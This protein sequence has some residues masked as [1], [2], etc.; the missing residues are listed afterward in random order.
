MNSKRKIVLGVAIAACLGLIPVPFIYAQSLNRPDVVAQTP[1]DPQTLTSADIE[2]LK[3][4]GEEEKMSRDVYRTLGDRWNLRIFG[5]IN[6]AEQRHMDRVK[7]LMQSYGI[8]DP[9]VSDR[10][11]VFANPELATMYT[12]LV[13]RGQT[14]LLEALKVGALIEETDIKDLRDRLNATANPQIKATY[15]YL[16][17]G[18]YNHLQA[19]VRQIERQGGA[20]TPQVLS[21][22]EVKAILD[23]GHRPSWR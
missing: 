6:Q 11:G 13:Q 9:V 19:F 15:G 8:A 3:F 14:S 5:N 16:L 1:T 12:Q 22:P 7:I 2:G 20:Y 18:S 23:Q 10:V 21:Q 17:Q 4:M